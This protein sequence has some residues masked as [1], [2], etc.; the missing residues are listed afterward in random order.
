HL[1]EPV[2]SVLL[3]AAARSRIPLRHG[4]E[5]LHYRGDFYGQ[6]GKGQAHPDGIRVET[7]IAVLESL[8]DGFTEL[9]CHPGLGD[10]LDSMYRAERRREVAALCDPR[11]RTAAATRGVRFCSFNDWPGGCRD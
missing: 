5:G 6:D 1:H 9:C 2:R 8:E 7:L 4:T 10:D 3:D 11:I